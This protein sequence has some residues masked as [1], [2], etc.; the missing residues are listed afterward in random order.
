MPPK[1]IS[2]ELDNEIQTAVRSFYNNCF[3]LLKKQIDEATSVFVKRELE[4]YVD[5]VLKFHAYDNVIFAMGHDI[6]ANDMVKGYVAGQVRKFWQQGK[7]TE[8]VAKDIDIA[9]YQQLFSGTRESSILEDIEYQDMVDAY[10]GDVDKA[11]AIPQ[12]FDY[13]DQ[14][15]EFFELAYQINL[16][17]DGEDIVF[18][19]DPKHHYQLLK[20]FILQ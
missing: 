17:H 12:Q 18:M 13:D 5:V 15:K 1:G 16:L 6:E 9:A 19:L 10:D 14:F 7:F 20:N 3:Y 2:I 4:E 8:C 11:L